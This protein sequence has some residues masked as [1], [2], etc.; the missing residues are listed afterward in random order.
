MD[1]TVAVESPSAVE[2]GPVT[3]VAA[4]VTAQNTVAS[5]GAPNTAADELSKLIPANGQ[6][7]PMTIILAGIAVLGGG[8]GW[9]FYSQHSKQKHELKLAEIEADKEKLNH[10]DEESKKEIKDIK[11]SLAAS[12]R[13]ISGRVDDLNRKV[14]G[15]Q[16]GLEEVSDEAKSSVKTAMKSVEDLSEAMDSHVSELKK[17]VK[18]VKA[19]KAPKVPKTKA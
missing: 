16:D 12:V 8:A 3:P 18:T 17:A 5:V 14:S 11:S 4:P 13:D 15:L 7:G 10:L 1:N 19:P 9:K 2:Q 6:I